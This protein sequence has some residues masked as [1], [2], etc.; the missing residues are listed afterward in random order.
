MEVVPIPVPSPRGPVN[1]YLVKSGSE[2]ALVDA[3]PDPGA[4]AILKTIEASGLRPS[5]VK[6]LLLTHT[7]LDH[8][9]GAEALLKA[10]GAELCVS[11]TEGFLLEH[12]ET[13][14]KKRAAPAR[15]GPAGRGPPGRAAPPRLPA[16]AGD[17]T[18]LLAFRPPEPAVLLRNGDRIEVG[19]EGLT[20]L[21]TPGHTVGHL[22]FEGPGLLFS[23]DLLPGEGMPSFGPRPAELGDGV[24]T[25]LLR[26]LASLEALGE[27]V[28]HPGHGPSGGSLRERLAAVEG[29]LARWEEALARALRRE[30]RGRGLPEL[31]AL[32]GSPEDGVLLADAAALLEKLVLERRAQR[33]G[34]LFVGPKA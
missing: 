28:L 5:A 1:C 13:L 22:C 4:K 14:A 16:L 30:R 34:D 11:A 6:K 23:G 20:A 17:P 12:W 21:F 10:T 18:Q 3:G 24:A 27:G 2:A 8:L 15:P 25:S 26:S 29:T 32:L 7:H 31:A 19:S 9:R 33:R